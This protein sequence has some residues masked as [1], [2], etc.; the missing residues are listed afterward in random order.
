MSM[1][2]K[3]E[4]L[5]QLFK[6]LQCRQEL[7]EFLTEEKIIEPIRIQEILHSNHNTHASQIATILNEAET[8]EQL[9]LVEY[10]WSILPVQTICLTLVSNNAKREF[11]Y[12]H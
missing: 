3:V 8:K 7:L 4:C 6:L 1:N 10:D 11:K 2:K 9:Q 5:N 12:G